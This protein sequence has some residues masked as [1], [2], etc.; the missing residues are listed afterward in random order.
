MNLCVHKRVFE[1]SPYTNTLTMGFFNVI[2]A[3]KLRIN[4]FYTHMVGVEN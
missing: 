1:T 4:P 2:K 3:L